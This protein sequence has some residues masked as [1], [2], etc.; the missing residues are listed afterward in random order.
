MLQIDQSFDGREV[1]ANK[2]DKLQLSLPEN[3]TTGYRWD[4]KSSGEPVCKLNDTHYDA[5]TDAVGRGGTRRW[6]FSI[7][8]AGVT[9][10]QLEYRRSF[11]P[12]N[13][14]AKSFSLTVRATE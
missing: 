13:P 3:P 14:A 10:I 12:S 2:L 8:A 7:V 4:L 1:N 9:T 6:E 5:P 11:E